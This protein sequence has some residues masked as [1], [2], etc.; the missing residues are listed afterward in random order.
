MRASKS[1]TT[2]VHHL[3]RF[4]RCER[5]AVMPLFLVSAAVIFGA[6]L[7][8]L[9][10]ARHAS[11]TTR[12]Q[13]ALDGAALA[14]GRLASSEQDTSVLL[15]EARR[16]FE[17]N[18]PADYQGSGI[19]AGRLSLSTNDSGRVLTLSVDGSL[20]LLSTGFLEV[21]AAPLRAK[22]TVALEGNSNLEV[23]F[24][25]DTSATSG[26]PN[27]FADSLKELTTELLERG[28]GSTHIGIVP[29]SEVVNVGSEYR[30]W[31][32]RWHNHAS[33]DR[34]TPFTSTYHSTHWTGCIAEPE[35]WKA[36]QLNN[37]T[38]GLPTDN[39]MPV[40]ARVETGL[41]SDKAGKGPNKEM[42]DD[43][44]DG[45]ALTAR[46]D[47]DA[48]PQPQ[49]IRALHSTHP[50]ERLLWVYFYPGPGQ[51]NSPHERFHLYSV[52]EPA[53]CKAD[54]K[55][56]YLD[57][58][59]LAVSDAMASMAQ[60]TQPDN[61]S[62]ALP[63][64]GLLW[65]WRMLA[66][67]WRGN[68][69]WYGSVQKELGKDSAR[70]IVV[71]TRG[72]NTEWADLSKNSND[73]NAPVRTWATTVDNDFTFELDYRKCGNENNCKGTPVPTTY[74]HAPASPGNMKLAVTN[75]GWQK[76]VSSLAMKDP[77]KSEEDIKFNAWPT[78]RN[79][80]RGVCDAIKV[81]GVNVFALS[82]P[83]GMLNSSDIS[84]CVSGG[85]GNKQ[86]YNSAQIE[87]LREALLNLR[88]E[89]STLRLVPSRDS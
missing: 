59:A 88:S 32:A 15:G 70:A 8:G 14:M 42:T 52:H 30:G 47:K 69:G 33:S 51:G 1:A 39:F 60:L 6:S 26:I 77:F 61:Q 84:Y 17:A 34:K 35:P 58:N 68:A 50:H 43:M 87:T 65:S 41:W 5:G 57:N 76:P 24:A 27:S 62:K 67:T 3:R 72:S 28:Q 89:S 38:P 10:L 22:S 46:P 13:N 83:A 9:D 66:P 31:V 21:S 37:I 74:Y 49:A 64:A 2:I 73:Y 80:L 25:L 19:D 71:V 63:A 18:F 11:A 56:R 78:A 23:V 20:P 7:G 36:P 48:L 79:Y 40:V 29:Y 44:G 4:A 85:E 53:S 16:Y 45:W 82:P 54:A 81:D 86:V 12:L 75:N 55:V